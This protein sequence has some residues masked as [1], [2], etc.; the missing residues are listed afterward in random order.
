MP[1]KR[2]ASLVLT[3]GLA[4]AAPAAAQIT[5]RPLEVSGS[6]GWFI[7]DGRARMQTSLAT[8]ATLGWR[9]LPGLSIEGHATFGP[10][11]ADTLPHQ[12]HNFTQAGVDFRWNLR[13][14][15][16]KT[17]PY[18]LTGAGVGESHTSGHPPDKLQK[19]SASL[20]L[21]LLQTVFNQRTYLRLEVRDMMFR[22]REALEFSNHIAVTAGIQFIIG[23]KVIDSDRDSVYDGIDKC[24]NTPIGCIVDK[25]GCPA[26]SDG[27][28]VCDGLDKCPN[29]PKGATVDAQ[30]CPKDSDGDGVLDGIDQ[31]PNTPTGCTVDVH[32][33]PAD[34]DSDGVCDGVDVCPNTP[35]GLRVDARG[36]PIEVM[37]KE[38]QLL[39][40][41][42]IRL[43]NVQ[44]DTGK[45]SIKAGS[46]AVL[47]SVG[48][49][50]EQYPTLKIEV[51]GHTDNRGTPDKNQKLSEAR[52]ASVLRYVTAKF[53]AINAGQFT[54]KGYGQS[55]PIAPNSTTAGRAKNR[56]VEFKVMNPGALRVERERRRF[57][58]KTGA[59]PPDTTPRLVPK[60]EAAPPDTTRKP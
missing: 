46:Y 45:D 1:S 34:A 18:V 48:M 6:A 43:S 22:E 15:E 21:G 24:P 47:D 31:C 44:F 56:R 33:C 5:G 37:D 59:A 4:L 41:G 20:G 30:G 55:A 3:L 12:R 53:P 40:T 39:D 35:R 10:S 2:I 36:C 9:V 13:D 29:T 54:S 14:A 7:P 49:V 38:T 17:V 57:V 51:G 8:Q 25:N 42:M 23:G 58:P 19:G 26:D 52:A 27:D 16:S 60:T 28:G 11:H 32:G 50:L